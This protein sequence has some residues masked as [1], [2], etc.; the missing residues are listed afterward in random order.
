M[1]IYELKEIFSGCKFDL[2]KFCNFINSDDE[3]YSNHNFLE[4][5]KNSKFFMN[6][7]LCKYFVVDKNNILLINYAA[8]AFGLESMVKVHEEVSSIVVENNI[9]EKLKIFIISSNLCTEFDDD[10]Y[11]K[12]IISKCNSENVEIKHFDLDFYL[13]LMLWRMDDDR[14]NRHFPSVTKLSNEEIHKDRLY[15][16]FSL[17]A[18]KVYHREGLYNFLK[19]NKLLDRSL[20]SAHWEEKYL[21]CK[22]NDRSDYFNFNKEI[23]DD[24]E[25]DFLKNYK[26]WDGTLNRQQI[27]EHPIAIFL[28]KYYYKN[29]YFQIITESRFKKRNTIFLTE[30][31]YKSLCS[32]PFILYAQPGSLKKLHQY[33]FKTFGHIIDE[34]YDEIMDANERLDFLNGEVLRIFSKDLDELKEMYLSCIPILEHNYNVMLSLKWQDMIK[35][36]TLE[37]KNYLD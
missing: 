5:E 36:L 4:W 22:R 20:V 29:C 13:V 34:S 21:D 6:Y 19:D 16:F 12:E 25:I 10:K 35:D 37:M 7:G 27:H 15:K 9:K 30:K 31:V 32:T 33:E 28:P 26:L 17:N 23:Y 1:N 2:P 24:T 8:E 14:I 11:E 3:K 18:G